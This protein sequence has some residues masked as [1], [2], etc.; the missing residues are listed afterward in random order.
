MSL[1]WVFTGLS[2]RSLPPLG[3]RSREQN[4]QS[5]VCHEPA[6]CLQNFSQQELCEV[7]LNSHSFKEYCISGVIV[8]ATSVTVV[9]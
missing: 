9:C 2:G 3:I 1:E 7:K 5:C 6:L 8:L 4:V